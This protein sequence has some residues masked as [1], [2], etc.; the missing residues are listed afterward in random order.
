MEK[1]ERL[2]YK[3]DLGEIIAKPQKV[4]GGFL[5][6]MYHVITEKA[7]YAI[8]ILNPNI[9][10]RTEALNNMIN[11]EEVAMHLKN[12]I[13][14]ITGKRFNG[15]SVIMF[16]GSYYII[17]D[18]FNG[19]SITNSE[20]CEYHCEQIGETLAKIHK[21]N[22]HIQGMNKDNYM[23]KHDWNMLLDQSQNNECFI[24]LRDC[25]N[26]LVDWENRAAKGI[27]EASS[28]QIISHRDL[29]P[30]NVMW[31]DNKPYIIDWE[32]SGYVNPYQELVE[33]LNYWIINSNGEYDKNRFNAL[34]KSYTKII[35]IN[36]VNWGEIINC[37]Y[38][39]MLDWLEYSIQK[40]LGNEGFDNIEIG[41]QQ[42]KDTVL[43]L[44][45]F[46]NQAVLLKTWIKE[47]FC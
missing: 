18:W 31:N 28:Y 10:N 12:D 6:K 42:A 38:V 33:V 3:Y 13:S 41:L 5:H 23:H 32:A 24:L 9:M 43:S 39:G 7:E 36:N 25:I 1:L 44:R 45:N 29:D 30:K 2:C 17:Y 37:G 46:D 40:A 27:I 14:L 16:D 35:D 11:A 34:M 21:A 8:K 4:T 20:I 26:E 47:F 19:R 22:I 15:K